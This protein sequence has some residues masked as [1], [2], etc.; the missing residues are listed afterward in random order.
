VRVLAG[1]IVCVVA[2]SWSCRSTP[3]VETREAIELRPLA[4]RVADPE[5]VR[6][7]EGVALTLLPVDDWPDT[8]V[9]RQRVRIEWSGGSESFDAVLQRRP[10]E[11]SLIGLGPMNLVGFRVALLASDEKRGGPERVDF[12]NRSGMAL[13]FAPTHMLADVQRAFYP[14]LLGVP[15][16]RACERSGWRGPVGI[17]EKV[18]KH[19]LVERRFAIRDALDQGSVVVRYSNWQDEPSVPR[20]VELVN[21][22]LGYRITIETLE[23]LAVDTPAPP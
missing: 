15:D 19:H 11:L 5:R 23:S 14:W 9:L 12:E 18:G 2:L 10:G 6:R 17:W 7:I 3:V 21:G 13:P 1:L 22:W 4:S 8:R 20:H 16:C